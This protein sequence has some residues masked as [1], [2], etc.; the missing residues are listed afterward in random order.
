MF[1]SDAFDLEMLPAY[2]HFR[3]ALGVVPVALRAR[4]ALRGVASAGGAQ[5][6]ER[7]GGAVLRDGGGGALGGVGVCG[8]GCGCDGRRWGG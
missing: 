2:A 8:R 6:V 4:V 5:A 7:G 3:G 1:F